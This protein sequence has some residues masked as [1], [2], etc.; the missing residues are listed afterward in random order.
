[1]N[2]VRQGYEIPQ[3]YEPQTAIAMG[4]VDRS[5]PTDDLATEL[6]K[7][8]T[9]PRTRRTLAEQ[10]FAGKWGNQAEFLP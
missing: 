2:R 1:L 10:V 6:R 3:G 8:E 9:G 4:Y 5:D 7:R